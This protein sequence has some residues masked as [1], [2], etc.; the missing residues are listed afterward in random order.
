MPNPGFERGWIDA[1]RGLALSQNYY[2]G[3]VEWLC[4]RNGWRAF[5]AS[6][7]V[8]TKGLAV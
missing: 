3:T 2:K 6:L 1:G 4:W 7:G 8:M 5:W